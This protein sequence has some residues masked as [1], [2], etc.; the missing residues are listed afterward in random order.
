MSLLLTF[1]IMLVSMSSLKKDEGKTRAML[2][3]IRKAFG[4]TKSPF[5]VP[6]RSTQTN[7][8]RAERASL[9]AQSKGGL[10][11]SS[12]ES[13]GAGGSHKASQRISEGTLIT[14]G[15][16]AG[17]P[18]FQ[19]TLSPELK[20]SLDTVA[21]VIGEKTN[22]IVVRGHASPE[23]LPNDAD[24]AAAAVGIAVPWPPAQPRRF[25]TIDDLPIRS[26]MD[27]SFAR[28]RAVA[29]Y[30]ISKK[31]DSR[32]LLVTAAG[33]TEQRLLTRNRAGQTLNRRVDVFLI[34]SYI[35]HPKAESG[36]RKAES[37]N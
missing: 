27:L 34:D 11:R 3:A 22:Q 12:R 24:F 15:G 5:G 8:S 4:P 16:P 29:D 7:S 20:R 25:L 13:E 35:A 23:P 21:R 36:R 28:S 10:E 30:L 1:F 6:G 18:R 9:G 32:R 37:G 14:L 17:F 33:D 26:Q 31:I 2:D 19:A